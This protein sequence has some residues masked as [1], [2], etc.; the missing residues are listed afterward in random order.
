[1]KILFISLIFL[2]ISCNNEVSQNETS[3]KEKSID[4]TI[5]KR[6][7]EDPQYHFLKEDLFIDDSGNIAYR[8][9]D[10]TVPGD[11]RNKFITTMHSDSGVTELRLVI[12]TATLEHLGDLYYRDKKNVYY[13]FP[14]MD[15]GFF[16]IIKEADPKSIQIVGESWYAKDKHHIFCR[17]SILQN[18]DYKTFTTFPLINEGDTVRWLGKDKNHVYDSDDTLNQQTLEDWNVSL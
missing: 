17:G 2:T 15:G 12:D 16:D 6:S 11:I 1:M 10:K 8:A 18:A 13:H 9:Y 7:T 4:S 14:M 3:L 5:Q